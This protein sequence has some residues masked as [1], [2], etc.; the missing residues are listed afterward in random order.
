MLFWDFALKK[1][2]ACLKCI[3]PN[4]GFATWKTKGIHVNPDILSTA[5]MILMRIVIPEWL[6]GARKARRPPASASVKRSP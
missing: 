3:K 4:F 2:K 5:V 1:N 6:R